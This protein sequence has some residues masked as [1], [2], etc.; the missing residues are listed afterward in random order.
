MN[1]PEREIH[2]LD[3][4]DTLDI[5]MCE[6]LQ[7][8]AEVLRQDDPNAR[9]HKPPPAN[10]KSARERVGLVGLFLRRRLGLLLCEGA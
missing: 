3:V 2:A 10:R 9:M 7:G 4:L 6:G 8:L 1:S 5:I